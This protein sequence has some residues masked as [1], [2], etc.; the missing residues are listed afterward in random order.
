MI[1][2]TIHYCWINNNPIPT[3]L[4][5]CIDSWKVHMPDWRIKLWNADNFDVYSVPFVEQAYNAGMLA[6]VADYIRA[7][8]LYTEGGGYTLIRMCLCARIWI[9]CLKT[10]RFQL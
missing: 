2:K 3:D 4:L 5:E 1:P 8:A 10:V 6:F 7:Y 9:L